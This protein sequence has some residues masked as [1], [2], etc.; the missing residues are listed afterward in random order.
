MASLADRSSRYLPNRHD[1][2]S[3]RLSRAKACSD[4]A[5]STDWTNPDSSNK[6]NS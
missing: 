1:S 5:D 6:S 2:L 4:Y 3:S